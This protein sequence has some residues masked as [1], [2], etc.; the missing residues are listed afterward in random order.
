MVTVGI[1]NATR[2]QST[3]SGEEMATDCYQILTDPC[4]RSEELIHAYTT[5]T[6]LITFLLDFLARFTCDFQ[7]IFISS[8]LTRMEN[9][10]CITCQ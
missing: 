9:I 6:T 4:T 5:D 7:T 10:E 2:C 3:Q 1:S 8:A